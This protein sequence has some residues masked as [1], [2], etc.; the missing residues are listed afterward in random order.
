MTKAKEAGGSPARARPAVLKKETSEEEEVMKK[1]QAKTEKEKEKEKE[2]GLTKGLTITTAD[3]DG[4]TKEESVSRLREEME[5]TREELDYEVV[6]TVMGGGA[7]DMVVDLVDR[8]HEEK[9]KNMDPT[10][11]RGEREEHEMSALIIQRQFRG[12]R[13]RKHLRHVKVKVNPDPKALPV[14]KYIEVCNTHTHTHTPSR[15]H[16]PGAHP[17]TNSH[18]RCTPRHELTPTTTPNSPPPL[19]PIGA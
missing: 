17:V 16:T 19:F 10:E 14:P 11:V 13:V 15:T 2:N 5:E 12:H 1:V 6:E 3:G 9:R 8:L 7:K 18:P 4:A